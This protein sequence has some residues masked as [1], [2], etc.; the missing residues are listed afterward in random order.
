MKPANIA[1]EI[2]PECLSE[3]KTEKG[4]VEVVA[5]SQRFQHPA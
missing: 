4:F 3:P 5:Q 2:L 1:G